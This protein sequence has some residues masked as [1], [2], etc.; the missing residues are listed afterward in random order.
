MKKYV[1]S[2][3]LVCL[4]WVIMSSC[5][6]HRNL[7]FAE[8]FVVREENNSIENNGLPILKIDSSTLNLKEKKL[9][10]EKELLSEELETHVSTILQEC[11]SIQ[12][13]VIAV[14][15]DFIIVKNKNNYKLDTKYVYQFDLESARWVCMYLD[16]PSNTLSYMSNSWSFSRSVY[17]VKRR[18]RMIIKDCFGDISVIYVIQGKDCKTPFYTTSVWNPSDFKDFITISNYINDEVNPISYSIAKSR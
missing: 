15:Q 7:L 3:V 10:F 8:G 13:V 1:A 9:T 6:T 12:N 16:I 11:N 2:S 17:V 5:A 4:F 18:N 14:S